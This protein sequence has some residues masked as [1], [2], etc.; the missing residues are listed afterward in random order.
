VIGALSPP[1]VRTIKL[2]AAIA[3]W[4]H[5]WA[6]KSRLRGQHHAA[7]RAEDIAGAAWCVEAVQLDLL[8]TMAFPRQ[9]VATH[10]NAFRL[11]EPFLEASHLPPVATGLPPGCHRV[12]T[13][14][15][16]NHSIAAA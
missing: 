3:T 1:L 2:A 16:H 14:L 4:G 13:G 15:P 8:L 11:F 6:T 10:G 5:E 12:A 9:P 7:P